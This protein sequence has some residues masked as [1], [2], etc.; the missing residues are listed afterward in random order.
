MGFLNPYQAIGLVFPSPK[1]LLTSIG[2]FGLVVSTQ[3]ATKGFFK[4]KL[5]LFCKF[6]VENVDGLDPLI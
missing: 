1:L 5:F 2:L 3:E 6:N 4:A